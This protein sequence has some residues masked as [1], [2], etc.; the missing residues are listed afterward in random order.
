MEEE[1]FPH[2]NSLESDEALEEERRLCYVGMTRA[3]EYLFLTA[4]R[5]RFLWGMPRMMR[6]SRFLKEVPEKFLESYH[7]SPPQREREHIVYD[8][9]EKT[10]EIGESVHHRDFGTG[11]VQKIYKTSLGLTYDVFFPRRQTRSAR[12]WQ[13]L[14]NSLQLVKTL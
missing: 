3:K 11:V 14:P 9:E 2:A 10:F 13:N 6:P 12:L 7:L 5:F 8:E 4:S 1:L